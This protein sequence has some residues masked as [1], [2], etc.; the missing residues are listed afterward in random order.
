ME[1]LGMMDQA[2]RF[3]QTAVSKNSYNPDALAGLQRAGQW[4]LNDYLRQFDE[5]RMAHNR[6]RAVVVFEEAEAY[7]SK[8]EKLGVRLVFLESARTAFDRSIS[9]SANAYMPSMRFSISRPQI[10]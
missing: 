7:A 5:F 9:C 6:A 3:Y 4:V 1:E 8:I 2:A 10:T